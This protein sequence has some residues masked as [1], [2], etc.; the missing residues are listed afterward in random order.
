VQPWLLPPVY[1]RLRT[2]QGRFLAELRPGV[3]LFLRFGGL[4]YDEDDTVGEKLDVYLRWVQRVL[5]RYEGYTFQLTLGDKGCYLYGAFGA[6]LAHD[7]AAR[8]RELVKHKLRQYQPLSLP[9][10]M[11]ERLHAI[12]DRSLA[13][14]EDKTG[15]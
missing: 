11:A 2:G 15:Q 9:E 14:A 1:E 7:D 8:A 5:A 12:I 4:A 13:E 6:P 10:D 3:A